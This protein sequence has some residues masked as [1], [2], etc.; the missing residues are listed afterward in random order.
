MISM[1]QILCFGDSNTYGLIPATKDRYDWNTRWTGIL[2][3]KI[4]KNGYRV[5]EEGLCGRTTI[6]ENATR[7]GRKGADLLPIILETHKPID[8]V[9]LML[10]TNDCKTAYGATAEKIGSGIELLIKQIKDSDP[11]INIILVSPIELGEGVWE[12]GFDTEFNENSVEVSKQ[13][14]EVYRKI[15]EKYD[16]DFVAASEYAR[17]SSADREH[18]NNLVIESLQRLFIIS[19]IAKSGKQFDENR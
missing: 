10:G 6:F 11:D 16:A 17:P 2:S 7:K 14:P 4:E 13:L 8:T 15:A 18:L 5:V 19:F 1:K 12:E 3:K 9:V